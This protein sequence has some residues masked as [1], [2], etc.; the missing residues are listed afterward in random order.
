MIARARPLLGTY[1]EI[2]CEHT[3]QSALQDA[4]VAVET[5]HRLMSFHAAS[6]ELTKLNRNAHRYAVAVHPWTWRVLHACQWFHR[7]SDGL[8]DPTIAP[9]LVNAGS[10]PAPSNDSPDADASFADVKFLDQRRVKFGR[11]LW[12]DL[13]GIA[14]GF[15]V[16]VAIATLRARGVRQATVNAGGDLRVIGSEPAEIWLRDPRD[17]TKL[18]ATGTLR[19]GACATS[20]NYF[21]EYAGAWR[22][23]TKS[24]NTKPRRASVSVIAKRCL[25]ADALTKV[26]ALGETAAR[27]LLHRLQADIVLPEI[28]TERA[29]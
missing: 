20:G 27:P 22:I 15:A 5:V 8:F 21:G 23:V 9:Q 1:V 19:N 29:A 26:V 14:K 17:P 11:P 24:T 7:E 2:C 6:S 28:V 16:D 13:G 18:V 10:L 25:W 12:I 3:S 4:F